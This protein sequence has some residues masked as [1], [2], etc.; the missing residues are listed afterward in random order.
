MNA[1]LFGATSPKK[2]SSTGSASGSDV[3]LSNIGPKEQR[4]RLIFG[5]VALV[6]G[7]AVTALLIA[8]NANVLWRLVLFIPFAGAGIG[9]FQARDKT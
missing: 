6:F 5:I 1:I 3:C 8:T 9:Y 2:S 7:L 4:K